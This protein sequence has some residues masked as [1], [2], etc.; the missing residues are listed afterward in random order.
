M[1]TLAGTPSRTAFWDRPII[2]ISL[3]LLAV[4]FWGLAYNYVTG[5]I[6]AVILALLLGGLKR[7]VW[8]IVALMVHQFTITSYMVAAPFGFRISLQLLLLILVGL[9]LWRAH[10][11]NRL[12][13][14]PPAR[15]LLLPLILLI[16]L[17]LISD[18]FNSGLSLT[19][20]DFRDWMVGLMMVCF[21]P[22]AIQNKRDLKIVTTAVLLLILISAVIGIFQYFN[23]LGMQSALLIPG[24]THLASENFRITGITVGTL[25][26]SYI[27]STVFLVLLGTFL[28]RGLGRNTQPLA[29]VILVVLAAALFFTYTRSSI[30][31]VLFGIVSLALFIKTRIKASLILLASLGLALILM[32]SP[33]SSQYLSGRSA[34]VQEES[35]VSR[36]ILWQAGVN[37]AIS[38]PVLGIG[39]SNFNS[40]STQYQSAVNPSLIAY[41][42]QQ[43]WSYRTLGNESPHN[44]FINIWLSYGT[45]ALILFLWLFIAV[46]NNFLR[47]YRISNSDF[48]KGLAVGLAAALVGYGINTLYHNMLATMPLFWILAG[49]SLAL[50][51]LALS[52]NAN[53]GFS[54]PDVH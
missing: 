7:P 41:E 15:P 28:Y 16:L 23:I 39:S 13:I 14:G 4:V 17:A 31:A 32:L 47:A 3:L 50:A 11:Q 5:I 44:D 22:L 9:I 53:T 45:P 52:Q 51:R 10:R 21:I 29:P 12:E 36:E 33:L 46:L 8:A 25:E 35:T 20:E 1:T 24:P 27:L 54:L 49:F 18:L 40:L 48:L 42:K 43:Y 19:F 37:I 26:A 6:L 30:L 34:V 2:V 38:H